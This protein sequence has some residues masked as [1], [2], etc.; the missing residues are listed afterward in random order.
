M[1]IGLELTKKATFCCKMQQDGK[2]KRLS[3]L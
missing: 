2:R 3:D 1:K